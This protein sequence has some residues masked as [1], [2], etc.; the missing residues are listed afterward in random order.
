MFSFGHASSTV[1]PPHKN[2]HVW[3]SDHKVQAVSY[4]GNQFH[5]IGFIKLKTLVSSEDAIPLN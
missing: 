5:E 2:K 3:T 1:T 4:R